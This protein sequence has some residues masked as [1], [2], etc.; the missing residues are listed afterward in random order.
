M[1]RKDDVYGSLEQK[2]FDSFYLLVETTIDHPVARVW[3]HALNIGGWMSAH[4][5]ETIAGQ[6][7][8]VGHFERVYPRALAEDVP[9]PHYHLY[10]IA[11]LEPMK[12]IV[13]EV[14]HEKGGS[15]GNTRAKMSFDT[16]FLTD[17]G[18]RTL[19]G[20]H[21]VDLHMGKGDEEWRASRQHELE[22]VRG[23]LHG[24]FDNLRQL[25]ERGS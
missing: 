18:S 8:Q 24:Y 1:L 15:Y 25:I 14:F 22:A 12:M 5:L 6:P 7:G 11:Y 17:L 13:I 20:F 4:R 10:G 21:M 9:Q 16:L 2:P 23:M 3:P 19:L